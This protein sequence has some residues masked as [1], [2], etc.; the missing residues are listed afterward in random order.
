V[1]W[2][3][4]SPG[5][6]VLV[7]WQPAPY[8]EKWVICRRGT[9]SA[10]IVVRGVPGPDGDL[11][12]IDGDGA[13]TP[14]PLDYWDEDRGVLEIGGAHTPPDTTPTWITIET[15]H[16][17]GGRPPNQF[18]GGDGATHTYAENAA[19]LYVEKGQHITVR[20]CILEGSGNGLFVSTAGGRTT[21]VLVEGCDFHD[22]GIVGSFYEHNNYSEATGI[23]FQY[24]HFGPLCTGCL[25]NNLKDRSAG[26]VV[27][28]NWIES[29]NRQLDLVE[30]HTLY[31]LPSYATTFVYGNVLIEHDGDGN[32]QIV[33][34]GGD[35]RDTN[36]YR[37]GMLYFYDNT[38]V[39]TRSDNTTLFRLSTDDAH[40]DA[41]NN[42]FHVT[43]AGRTL[44]ALD[45]AGTLDLRSNWL[46]DGWVI[47]H[48]ESFTGSVND[49]GGNIAGPAPGFVDEAVQDYHLIA[50]SAG[51]DAGTVL[52][53][54]AL[55]LNNV[56]EEYIKHQQG[57]ARALVGPLDL[58][59]F[60]FSPGPLP[61]SP[62][63]LGAITVSPT[64][65]DLSWT[66]NADNESG[67]TVE[68]SEDDGAHWS[69]VGSTGTD[70]TTWRDSG[71]ASG[72]TYTYRVSATNGNGASVA[73]NVASVTTGGNP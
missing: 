28:Y 17:R 60:E 67:F 23:V 48:D 26:T 27:R 41:R 2:D 47:T 61:A 18:T 29:G 69:A 53:P 46:P 62:S 4:L 37:K 52:A 63:G 1:P 20:G 5:D 39:S 45:D 56:V 38:V 68:R 57:A 19:A 73:S 3:A 32:S 58:G 14:A 40:A 70:I 34:Y 10:P 16:I 24:N 54:A 43:T 31:A 49:L 9:A 51:V 11:P 59:A 42:I 7:H 64:E 36:F 15:L 22:N 65:I 35:G 55:S 6:T 72:T 8:R 50:G 30:S 66:D 25:G 71:L 21:D 44:A 12:I 33:Q 13:T